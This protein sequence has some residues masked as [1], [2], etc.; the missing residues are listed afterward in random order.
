MISKQT[1]RFGTLQM[2]H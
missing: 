1:H 2:Y